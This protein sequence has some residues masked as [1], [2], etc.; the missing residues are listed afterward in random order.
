M[1]LL[2]IVQLSKAFFHARSGRTSA[3]SDISLKLNSGETW[4]VVGPSGSG[5]TTL[6]RLISGLET[7]DSGEIFWNGE[8]LKPGD[9]ALR[10]CS[11]MLQDPAL[12]PH[13][14][15]QENIA[16]PLRARNCSKNQILEKLT[17]LAAR[18]GISDKLSRLPHETSGGEQQRTSLARALI[19]EPALLL[20]D[21]PLSNLEPSLRREFRELLFEIQEI[22]RFAMI[23]VTHDHKEALGNGGKLMVLKAG[24]ME[25]SGVAEEIYG[26]PKN[27]FVAGFF[28]EFGM[29]FLDCK[30]MRLADGI[31]VRLSDEIGWN[32]RAGL[33]P[34]MDLVLGFRP[35][36]VRFLASPS[37]DAIPCTVLRREF[38]G[39]RE[40]LRVCWNQEMLHVERPLVPLS[41]PVIWIAPKEFYLFDRATGLRIHGPLEAGGIKKG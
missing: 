1:A 20:L 31:H 23:S 9:P 3:L 2:E 40:M 4:T 8:K 41:A 16:L 14:T 28:G 39:S 18:L 32:L 34:H 6:L 33:A 22:R 13:L 27:R 24:R 17:P 21:E 30:T 35:E 19:R 15:L 26:S 5:K 10:P 7:A 38:L 37:S 36:A 25:Q 12:F 11:F 29:N